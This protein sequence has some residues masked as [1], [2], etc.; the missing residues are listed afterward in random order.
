MK[1]ASELAQ[2]RRA[3]SASVRDVVNAIGD[4]MVLCQR[5]TTPRVRNGSRTDIDQMER[6]HRL[7]THIVRGLRHAPYGKR[8]CQRNLSSLKRRCLQADLI[9]AINFFLLS[10]SDAFHCAPRTGLR[11]YTY[12]KLQG[13]NRLLV[14]NRHP[15]DCL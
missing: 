14:G 4:P 7:A 1:V 2:D 3:C 9:L 11:G 8:L 15:S 10:S 6:G 13:P 5:V 12:R